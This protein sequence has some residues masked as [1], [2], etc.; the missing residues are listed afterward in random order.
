[1]LKSLVKPQIWPFHVVVLQTTAKK[2]TKVEN[3]RAGRAE[4]LFLATKYANL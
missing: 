1:M 4:I 3:A 2:W